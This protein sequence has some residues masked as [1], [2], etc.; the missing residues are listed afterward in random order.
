MTLAVNA[1]GSTLDMDGVEVAEVTNIGGPS[2]SRNAI[3]ATHHKSPNAWAEFIKGIKD[4]GEVSMDIQYVPTNATHNASAGLLSDFADDTTISVWTLTFPD[5]TV[6]TFPG[7]L[8]GFE[9]GAPIDD[10]LTASVTIKVSG[11]PT[12]A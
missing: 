3:D 10:K 11:A 8:T 2:L 7:F 4:A 6:W 1:F 5:T 9:P 12:L